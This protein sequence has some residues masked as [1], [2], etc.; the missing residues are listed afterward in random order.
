[1][2]RGLRPGAALCKF[3]SWRRRKKGFLF[4]PCL[5]DGRRGRGFSS[6]PPYQPGICLGFNGGGPHLAEPPSYR[7]AACPV[8]QPKQA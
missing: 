4:L 6:K 2:G 7:Q 1:M 8:G 3:R 5:S